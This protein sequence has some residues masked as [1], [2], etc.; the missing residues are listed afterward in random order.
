MSI[1]AVR[2]AFVALSLLAASAALAASLT[3]SGRSVTEDRALSGYR[4]IS[5]SIPGRVEIVQG[6]V[7]GIR[8]TADDN[9]M[10]EIETVV[11]NGSLKLRFRKS[12]SLVGKST[13][14]IAVSARNIEAIAVAGSGDVH[15]PA[16]ASPQLVVNI[17]GS[18]NVHLGGRTETLNVNISGS[19]DLGASKLDTQ[20]VK[21]SVAG[22]GD[23]VVWARKTLTVSVAGSGDIRYYGDPAVTRSVVGSG[24]VR[25]LGAAPS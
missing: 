5:L 11:E 2:L 4:G 21:V 15:A 14:R 12:M 1:R 18:G 25:R 6:A 22:S 9:V 10:P 19:G 23:A 3:G 16:L 24:S 20:S 8:I 17:A 7:E 13:I